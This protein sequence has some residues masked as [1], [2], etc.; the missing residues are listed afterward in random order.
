MTP[1]GTLYDL[2]GSKCAEGW[3]EPPFQ[4]QPNP[5][6]LFYL[7]SEPPTFSR[8]FLTISFQ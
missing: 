6:P 4:R 8:V 1:R 5:F 7:F 2:L 3:F